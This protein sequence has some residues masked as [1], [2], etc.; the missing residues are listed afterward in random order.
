MSERTL[1]CSICL[2]TFTQ[3]GRGRNAKACE[4]CRPEFH[5]RAQAT[6]RERDREKRPK[7]PR[8]MT[9]HYTVALVCAE[10]DAPFTVTSLGA[11]NAKFCSQQCKTR[12]AARSRAYQNARARYRKSLK[13]KRQLAKSR[14]RH[15]AR[16]RDAFVED[17]LPDEIYQRDRYTCRLCGKRLAMTKFAPHPK[18][19]SID[20]IIPLSQGGTH[21]PANVQAAHFICN[22]RKSDRLGGDQLLL[23]G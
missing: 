10:C 14:A 19:P 17:V 20:H 13:G 5:R 18:S 1:T 22:A 7:R 4:H 11:R 6:K 21:E 2:G 16:K 9:P 12:C 15:R 8:T 23:I 3:S